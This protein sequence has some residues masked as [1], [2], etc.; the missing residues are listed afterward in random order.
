MSLI[1]INIYIWFRFHNVA[2]GLAAVVALLH[3][4]LITLGV[5]AISH[6]IYGLSSFLMSR[7]LS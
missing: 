6:W 5:L 7:T 3:D 1:F 4:V 2:Y